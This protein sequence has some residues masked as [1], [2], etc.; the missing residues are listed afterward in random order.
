MTDCVVYVCD[1]E[2]RTSASDLLLAHVF[3][4]NNIN[5]FFFIFKRARTERSATDF[6]V[7]EFSGFEIKDSKG[8]EIA[9]LGTV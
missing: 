1:E 6:G 7:S 2:R 9:S 3:D 4:I 5:T 8:K